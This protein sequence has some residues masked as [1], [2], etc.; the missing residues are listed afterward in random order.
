MSSE[1]KKRLVTPNVCV[2]LWVIRTYVEREPEKA[3]QGD[4]E[5]FSLER[6]DA[7]KALDYLDA[8]FIDNRRLIGCTGWP[9]QKLEQYRKFQRL[10][11]CGA[12]PKQR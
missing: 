2:L 6:R 5:A 3:L 12:W 8:M 4:A 7:L 1:R 9:K 10:M 11:G